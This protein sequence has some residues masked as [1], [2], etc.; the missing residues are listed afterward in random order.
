MSVSSKSVVVGAADAQVGRRLHPMGFAVIE[1]AHTTYGLPA[2]AD[3]ALLAARR[4]VERF[5]R[6]EGPL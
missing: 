3:P 1:L 4:K 6:G 2:K 5:R